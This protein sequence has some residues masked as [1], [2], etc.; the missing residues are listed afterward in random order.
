MLYKKPAENSLALIGEGILGGTYL[1]IC[2]FVCL[3]SVL[4]VYS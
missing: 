3:L 2:V 4:G 1:F